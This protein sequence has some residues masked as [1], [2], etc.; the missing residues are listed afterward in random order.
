MT[1]PTDDE[2]DLT[3]DYEVTAPPTGGPGR[4]PTEMPSGEARASIEQLIRETEEPASRVALRMVTVVVLILI[5][6]A[7]TVAW[8]NLDGDIAE[9]EARI[10]QLE[11]EVAQLRA[12]SGGR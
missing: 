12:E 5:V 3:S 2:R 4:W 11:R 8:D 6:V 1:I 10:A 9:N 7:G